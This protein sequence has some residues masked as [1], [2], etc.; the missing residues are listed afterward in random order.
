MT[1]KIFNDAR[2]HG[3]GRRRPFF[4][5]W[6]FKQA[7][8]GGSFAAIP[9][10]YLGAD[11]K[12]DHAFIQILFSSP[13]ESRFIRFPIGAFACAPHGFEVIIGDNIFTLEG[14]RLSLPDI[15]LAAS[16][17]Y[18][19][20]VPLK[21]NLFSP[22]I[23]G[24]FAYVPGMQCRHGVLSLWHKT[25]GCVQYGGRRYLFDGAD[26]YIEKDW[27]GAFPDSWVWMQCGDNNMTLMCAIA[28]IPLKLM[29]FIGVIGV[30]RDGDRQYCFATYN[31]A[32]V[33]RL[34]WRNGCL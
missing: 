4:E 10:V 17:E 12:D 26:G 27:G 8:A 23:M 15:G 34:E 14:C 33:D 19:C 18:A 11:D 22:T 7:G 30:L 24:P 28:S 3:G 1:L 9:G 31:G 2:Y 25:S 21:T 6:Y 5:G 32:R 29:R 16:L 13:P 20:H